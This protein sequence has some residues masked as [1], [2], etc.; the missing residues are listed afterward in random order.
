[1]LMIEWQVEISC[2]TVKGR[3]FI[4]KKKEGHGGRGGTQVHPHCRS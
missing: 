1:M 2:V 4:K 3:E